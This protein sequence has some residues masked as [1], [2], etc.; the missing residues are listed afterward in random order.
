MIV[1]TVRQ[2]TARCVMY[3]IEQVL[4]TQLFVTVSFIQELTSCF[5]NHQVNLSYK[6]YSLEPFSTYV[7]YVQLCLSVCLC[8]CGPC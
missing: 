2:K 4:F 3:R 5:S 1:A 8:H 7:R 6:E